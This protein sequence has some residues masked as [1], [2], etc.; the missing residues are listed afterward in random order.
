LW[1]QQVN[2]VKRAAGSTRDNWSYDLNLKTFGNVYTLALNTFSELEN[3]ILHGLAIAWVKFYSS[4]ILSDSNF[5]FSYLLNNPVFTNFDLNFFQTQHWLAAGKPKMHN[6]ATLTYNNCYDNTGNFRSLT[7]LNDR[8]DL[9]LPLVTY[10]RLRQAMA[11]VKSRLSP[12]ANGLTISVEKFFGSF[13]KGSKKNRAILNLDINKNNLIPVLVERFEEISL[14]KFDRPYSPLPWKAWAMSFLPNDFRDFLYKYFFNKLGLNTR[15]FHFGGT[16]RDC[17]FCAIVANG[18]SPVELETFKH[19]FFECPTVRT[20]HEN[21]FTA[22]ST[23]NSENFS[24][25]FWAGADFPELT[26]FFFFMINQFLVW[27]CKLQ[28]RLPNPNWVFGESFYILFTILHSN[29]ALLAEF[30]SN[31]SVL[32]RLWTRLKRARW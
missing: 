10:F 6:V 1:A 5:R 16:T 23:P 24:N 8:Y 13:K 11:K 22:I 25:Q 2:W 3:P 14:V 18:L 26:Y 31:N 19:L 17:T 29:Q 9:N 20:V 15:T 7:D 32:F 12:A 4:F 28:K 21:I 30:T 27:R